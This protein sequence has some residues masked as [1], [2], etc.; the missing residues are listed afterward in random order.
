MNRECIFLNN[1]AE[2][3]AAL[4]KKYFALSGP[5]LLGIELLLASYARDA[6]GGE[7]FVLY[8]KGGVLYEV[9]ASHDSSDG[10]EGQWEPE[11]TLVKALYYRLD[12]GRLGSDDGGINVFADELRFLLAELDAEGQR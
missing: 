8:R 10:V 1:W 5:E 3:N 12:K 11:D 9:N 2:G 6:Y 7:A 4:L